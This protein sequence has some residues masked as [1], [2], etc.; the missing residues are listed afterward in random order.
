MSFVSLKKL[1]VSVAACFIFLISHAQ[2]DFKV[3][4]FFTAKNDAA[5]ISFV[6]EANRWFAEKGKQ[7]HFVYD[8]TNNWNNLNRFPV[9][10]Q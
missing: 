7:N 1:L 8:S 3:I 5:H 6:H 10:P 2:D 4:G 9:L